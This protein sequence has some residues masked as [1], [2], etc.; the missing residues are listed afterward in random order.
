MT[1][2]IVEVVA[3]RGRRRPIPWNRQ[4]R[5][6]TSTWRSRSDWSDIVPSP[7]PRI[8]SGNGSSGEPSSHHIECAADD[9]LRGL[10]WHERMA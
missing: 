3:K 6:Q 8:L 7:A 2:R 4:C 5:R 10:E 1:A 9:L